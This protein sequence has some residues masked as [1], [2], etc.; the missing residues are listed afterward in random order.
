MAAIHQPTEALG[1]MNSAQAEYL[2][3]VVS[4]TYENMSAEDIAQFT[5]FPLEEVEHML[6]A[7]RSMPRLHNEPDTW[8]T[9]TL[10][11]YMVRRNYGKQSDN[12]LLRWIK[13]NLYGSK[14]EHFTLFTIYNDRKAM[15]IWNYGA[16]KGKIHGIEHEFR[17]QFILLAHRMYQ[18]NVA[19]TDELIA[20]ILSSMFGPTT[21]M[22]ITDDRRALG[23]PHY[24]T[25]NYDMKRA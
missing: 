15:G 12:A 22:A 25:D 24:M 18:E 1:R 9:V 17:K 23:L 13:R 16:Y 11:R 7:F 4:T 20:E 14:E 8:A 2:L 19:P 10:R 6:A 5:G 3:V 21:P